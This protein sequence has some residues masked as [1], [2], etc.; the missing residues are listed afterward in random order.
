MAFNGKGA[1][2][3]RSF[4]AQN[5]NTGLPY[6]FFVT[7]TNFVGTSPQ[8]QVA[9]YYSCQ[10]PEGIAP[11]EVCHI[12]RTSV[13]LKWNAPHDDG[14]CPIT[15]YS[16]LRDGGPLDATL[17]EVHATDINNDPSLQSFT[18]TDLPASIVGQ[19]VS[20]T[21]RAHNLGGFSS[22]SLATSVVIADVPGKPLAGPAVVQAETSP[23]QITIVITEPDN[24][25]ST[26]HGYDV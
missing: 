18:V 7:S 25:G 5:L 9:L 24:G 19:K 11:P 1:P 12:T 10:K 14:G 22:T 15:S 8:S 16:I 13:E 4:K 17:I 21:L 6:K 3:I 20:F 26:L 2:D 23:T